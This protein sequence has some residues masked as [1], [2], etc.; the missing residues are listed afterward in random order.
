MQGL[1]LRSFPSIAKVNIITLME[2]APNTTKNTNKLSSSSIL[3]AEIM[4]FFHKL[5]HYRKCIF[6]ATS[7]YLETNRII[8]SVYDSPIFI[9]C[10]FRPGKKGYNIHT[11]IEVGFLNRMPNRNCPT[12]ILSCATKPMKRTSQFVRTTKATSNGTR[13]RKEF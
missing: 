8:K 1:P 10:F 5:Y 3:M 12:F 7:L 6:D 2:I 9:S 11:T 13:R 4:T